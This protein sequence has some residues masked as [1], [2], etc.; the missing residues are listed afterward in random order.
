MPDDCLQGAS[1]LSDLLESVRNITSGCR[2]ALK[3]KRGNGLIC[4]LREFV[5]FRVSCQKVPPL[6][7]P[8]VSIF[9]SPRE[10][11]F[12]VR[13]LHVS[14]NFSFVTLALYVFNKSLFPLGNFFFVRFH[15]IKRELDLSHYS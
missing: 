15:F 14:T 9:C 3:N 2:N 1:S 13:S 5:Y 11:P 12:C 7:K 10:F 6:P 4:Q 8:P